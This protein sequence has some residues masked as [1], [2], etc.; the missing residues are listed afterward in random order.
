MNI[1]RLQAEKR[2]NLFLSDTN[3]FISL[4]TE[5]DS[6]AI[7]GQRATMPPTATWRDGVEKVTVHTTL[8]NVKQKYGEL[9]ARAKAGDVDAAVELVSKVV[10]TEKVEALIKQ[11]PN[12]KV[13][14]VHAEEATGRN[15]LPGVYA[16]LFELYGLSLSDVTQTN[17][18]SH[19]GTDRVG[20]FLRR[21]RFDGKVVEGAEY[22]LV[23]DHITMGGTLRDLKD[24]I[25][26]K[27]GKV[28]VI[29]ILTASAG[30]TNL[31]PTDELI[32]ELT[33]KGITNE[34]LKELG[35]ADDIN[36][37]TKSEARE[38]LVLANSRGN[39]GPSQGRKGDSETR[40]SLFSEDRDGPKDGIAG[41]EVGNQQD[42]F[43]ETLITENGDKGGNRA[44][45][46]KE[47]DELFRDD[48]EDVEGRDEE[49]YDEGEQSPEAEAAVNVDAVDTSIDSSEMTWEEQALQGVMKLVERNREN[50]GL[51]MTAMRRIGGNLTKLRQAM[52]L[53]RDYDRQTVKDIIKLTKLMLNSGLYTNMD[54][55]KVNTFTPS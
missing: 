3:N 39:R 10:K 42:L 38:I 12:A 1:N 23:D 13:A 53:Q 27:G 35:I 55:K 19:T 37:L 40:S 2:R 20:R 44:L 28:V 8:R 6:E 43:D 26:S 30:G 25:E 45:F 31:R 49:L 24:Y 15:K 52:A 50:V 33:E 9:H 51:R 7:E 46:R 14:F 22:I 4:P 17:K 48:D 11:H 32:K 34:Q 41:L 16:A 5:G 54:V 36:G 21:A 29:T 18:P 47:E